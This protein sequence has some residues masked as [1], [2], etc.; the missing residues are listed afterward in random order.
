MFG[1]HVEILRLLLLRIVDKIIRNLWLDAVPGSDDG[2][3][4]RHPT[5]IR[6][7]VRCCRCRR[8]PWWRGPTLKTKLKPSPF[9]LFLLLVG[10]HNGKQ[11]G[12]R[13][14]YGQQSFC[15]PG[16]PR[17]QRI[18]DQPQEMSLPPHSRCVPPLRWRTAP[19]TRGYKLVLCY[20]K[21]LP[22]QGCA[23]AKF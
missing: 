20:N 17:L 2:R 15:S 10:R 9:P 14:V 5:T 21:T 11:K 7:R 3:L 8:R 1:L 16:R 13:A 23:Y 19:D 12:R 18:A 4:S 6:H 22:A